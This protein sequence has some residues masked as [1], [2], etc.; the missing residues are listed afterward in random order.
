MKAA[1]RTLTLVIV[2]LAL[3]ALGASVSHH[4]GGGSFSL[5]LVLPVVVWLGLDA[6]VVEGAVAAAAIGV[7]IDAAAGGPA[8]L[9]VFL[10]VMLFLASRAA[11]GTFDAES[12][13]G[14]SV[15]TGAGT[16]LFGLGAILLTRYVSPAEEA[17]RWGLAGR[18]LVEALLT[19]LCAPL[20]RWAL[21]RLAAPFQGEDPGLLR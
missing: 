21:D 1:L 4:I 9:C 6:G 2:A 16:L 19:G 20:V 7:V 12:L 13:L 10:S 5:A 14:F 8:G 17:P 18:V 3:V 15:L 11:A